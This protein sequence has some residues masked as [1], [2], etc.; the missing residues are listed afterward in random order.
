MSHDVPYDSKNIDDLERIS[1]E[2]KAKDDGQLFDELGAGAA[3]KKSGILGKV[4]GPCFLSP[5]TS[6]NIC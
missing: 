3:S 4:N 1:S 6:M 5:V 2:G